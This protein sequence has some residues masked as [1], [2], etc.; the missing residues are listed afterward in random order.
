[1]KA[2][3][4]ITDYDYFKYKPSISVL[5]TPNLNA[6]QVTQCYWMVYEKLYT[7]PAILRRT[8]FHRRF[9]RH[10]GR[11]LF[12]LMVNMVYRDQIKRKIAPNI[13]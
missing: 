5:D 12:Y 3:G 10:P 7:I 1:M 6:T 8:V 13:L 9:L 4:K 2:A 11:T